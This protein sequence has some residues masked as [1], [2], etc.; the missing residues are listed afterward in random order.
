MSALYIYIYI[1]T[2]NLGFFSVNYY[3]K[4]VYTAFNDKSTVKPN[5]IF[6]TRVQKDPHRGIPN[7]Y[8]TQ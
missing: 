3:A 5:I 7:T 6:D 1:Y 8:Y 4:E 2:E